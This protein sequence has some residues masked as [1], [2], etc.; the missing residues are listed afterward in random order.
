MQTKPSNNTHLKVAALI[1]STLVLIACTDTQQKDSQQNKFDENQARAIHIEH[2]I[3]P[4]DFSG[5][6]PSNEALKLVIDTYLSELLNKA[7]LLHQTIATFSKDPTEESLSHAISALE[8]LHLTYASGTFLW[9][10]SKALFKIHTQL[11]QHPLLP[12]YLDTVT[13]YPFS[14]LIHSDIA[15]TKEAMLEEFQLGDSYYVTLGFHALEVMLKGGGEKNR[16]ANDFKT[17]LD[18]ENSDEH[19]PELRRTRYAVLLSSEIKNNIALLQAHWFSVQHLQLSNIEQSND[20][21]LTLK[22]DAEKALKTIQTRQTKSSNVNESHFHDH[23]NI[24]KGREAFLR[25]LLFIKK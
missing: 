25:K 14:G 21:F 1:L 2:N 7:Q 3:K 9:E 24:L 17:L 4:I 20:Y 8:V 15:I 18:S 6:S 12:G 16:L 22:K 23:P 13:G 10:K 11:D 5:L 19:T